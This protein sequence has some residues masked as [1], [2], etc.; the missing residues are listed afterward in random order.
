MRGF[1][2]APPLLYVGMDRRSEIN[3]KDTLT[4]IAKSEVV[5]IPRV[6]VSTGDGFTATWEKAILSER[7][8]KEGKQPDPVFVLNCYMTFTAKEDLGQVR[9]YFLTTAS[10]G[11]SGVVIVSSALREPFNMY[12]GYKLS[13]GASV[14]LREAELNEDAI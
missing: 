5:K 1:G 13:V 11:V 9:N 4:T 8:I 10:E 6:P 12:K 2:M 7:E 14:S 3:P